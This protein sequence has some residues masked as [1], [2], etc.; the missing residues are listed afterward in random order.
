[1]SYAR[2]ATWLAGLSAFFVGAGF[3]IA[4]EAGLVMG[5]AMALLLNGVAYRHAGDAMFARFNI[6]EVDAVSSPSFVAQMRRLAERAALPTPRTFVF[7]SEQPNAFAT[8]RGNR[9]AS[10]AVTDGLLRRMTTRQITGVLAHELG[11][12]RN[13]DNLV[14][15]VTATLAGVLFGAACAAALASP[16][17]LSAGITGT[18]I[19]LALACLAAP[20]AQMAIS[21]DREFEADAAGA[22]ICGQPLWIASALEAIGRRAPPFPAGITPAFPATAFRFG[23]SARAG[24]GV[25]AL[26]STHPSSAERIRRLRILASGPHSWG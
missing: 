13:R 3:A 8:G 5:L 22:D 20:L 25:A 26:F 21:R 16:V 1:M 6:R 15:T 4:G 19:T 12:I 10:I 14:L 7:K 9:D 2:T 18:A 17:L 23:L 24:R 11:H